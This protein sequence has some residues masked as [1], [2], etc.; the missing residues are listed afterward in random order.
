MGA[1]SKARQAVRD[2]QAVEPPSRN[3]SSSVASHLTPRRCYWGNRFPPPAISEGNG[4]KHLPR[5]CDLSHLEGY[6]KRG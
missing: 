3:T 6:S 1:L 5:H 4:R 2:R